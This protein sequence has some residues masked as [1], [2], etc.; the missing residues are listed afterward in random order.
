MALH[1]VDTERGRAFGRGSPVRDYWLERCHGFE[2]VGADGRR[3]GRVR[4]FENPH[5][6]AFLRLGGLRPRVVPVSAVEMVWPAASVLLIADP[7]TP[8]ETEA[9][10]PNLPVID[11]G[12]PEGA[13]Q[14]V[15]SFDRAPGR[16]IEQNPA[17]STSRPRWEDETLP[18]WELVQ[19]NGATDQASKAP[20]VPFLLE[21]WWTATGRFV[22][23][24]GRAVREVSRELFRRTSD[25]SQ[26]LAALLLR[27]V[28]NGWH[29]TCVGRR[30]VGKWCRAAYAF[31]AN[32]VRRARLVLARV[33]LRVA[34]WVAGDRGSLDPQAGLS[35]PSDTP[36]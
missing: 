35:E 1:T 3:L 23:G 33:L 32:R 4:R 2:A 25:H 22:S 15:T 8:N 36:N 21:A 19:E 14:S 11:R 12:L 10:T 6:D 9:Q 17:G 5:G 31:G 30:A 7:D 20:R 29:L 27:R 13:T 34:V 16:A 28:R 26:K 18:W 24:G